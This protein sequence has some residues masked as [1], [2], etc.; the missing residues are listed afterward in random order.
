MAKFIVEWHES[1]RGTVEIEADDA[2]DAREKVAMLLDSELN[3][4]VQ[5]EDWDAEAY[6][7][8]D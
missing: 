7:V 6:E 3:K 1:R 8:T 2:W 5:R 4:T